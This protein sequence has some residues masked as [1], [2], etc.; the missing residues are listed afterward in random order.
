MLE[1][2]ISVRDVTFSYGDIPVL[3]HVSLEV[4]QG[5]FVAL[6][7]ENGSG[8]STLLGLLLGELPLQR[9][10]I[11]LL[12]QDVAHFHDWPSFGYL[13]QNGGAG[14][15]GFPANCLEIVTANLYSK[16]GLFRFPGKR[17]RERAMEALDAVGMADYARRL[18]GELSGGQLQRVL[19]AR[20]MVGEPRLLLLDEPT[21]GVD[22][23]SA[24]SLYEILAG[25]NRGGMT[26]LMVTH[27]M[28]RA[29]EY[30]S[31][32]FCLEDCTMLELDAEQQKL[33]LS[34]RHRHAHSCEHCTKGEDKHA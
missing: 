26:I 1:T 23:H 14:L 20:A 27:D 4:E 19:L 11:L 3:D 32:T 30:V 28:A 31:R 22:V 16:I 2:V 7:G 15:A 5:E 34:V 18:P 33:E 17:H 8:K 10:E 25:L 9:G 21:T 24:E 12:G 6:T 13:P 29:S